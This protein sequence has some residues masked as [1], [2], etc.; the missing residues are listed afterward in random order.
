MPYRLPNC[1]FQTHFGFWP[2]KKGQPLWKLAWRA[3]VE[4]APTHGPNE[5]RLIQCTWHHYEMTKKTL[6][7]RVVSCFHPWIHVAAHLSIRIL[8]SFVMF[9]SPHKLG[10]DQ[11][12]DQPW[13]ASLVKLLW[14]Q[15]RWTGG[16]I[17]AKLSFAL[18]TWPGSTAKDECGRGA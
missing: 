18:Q 9:C 6:I 8:Y 10:L 1:F 11:Q 13:P 4:A 17:C 2:L 3:A 15:N 5:H 12:I 14:P 7:L 16:W